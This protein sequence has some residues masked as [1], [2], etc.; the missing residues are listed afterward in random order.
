MNWKTAIITGGNQS[1]RKVIER[2]HLDENYQVAILE[3]D[4]EAGQEA[5]GVFDLPAQF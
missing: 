4:R 1:I 5:S 2:D 3:I